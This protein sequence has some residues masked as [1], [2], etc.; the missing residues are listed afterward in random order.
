MDVSPSGLQSARHHH[1]Q[2]AGERLPRSKSDRLHPNRGGERFA[3]R[4]ARQPGIPVLVAGRDGCS[5]DPPA[6]GCHGQRGRAVKASLH[7]RVAAH[8]GEEDHRRA[9]GVRASPEGPARGA[10]CR[11]RRRG[12][13]SDRHPSLRAGRPGRQLPHQAVPDSAG[14]SDPCA[15]G[16]SDCRC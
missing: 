6:A 5:R 10:F 14:C 9:G 11:L 2:L 8:P 15:H 3:G 13:V 12:L 7:P 16:E 1:V 4:Q